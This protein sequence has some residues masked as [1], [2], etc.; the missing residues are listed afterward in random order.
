MRQ[1]GIAIAASEVTMRA[2]AVGA[3]VGRALSISPRTP[4]LLM[5]RRTV[6]DDGRVKEVG[7]VWFCSDAYEFVCSTTGPIGEQG[8]FDIRNVAEK[9]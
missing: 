2:E 3:A 6:G 8:L 7:H 1:V 9:I 5:R 4:V